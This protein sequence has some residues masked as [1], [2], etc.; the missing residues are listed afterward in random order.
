MKGH[1]IVVGATGGVGAG[2][3]DAALAAGYR[4]I[5]VGRDEE[6]LRT[7]VADRAADARLTALA[8]SLAD[9]A[10]AAALADE[11]RRLRVRLEGIVVSIAPPRASGRLVERTAPQLLACVEQDLIPHFLAARHLLPLLAQ[12]GRT[13]PYLVLGCAAADH[14]WAGYGHVSIG[15]A[16]RKMLVHVLREESKD[17]PVRVQLV[18][19]EGQVCTHRNARMACPAWS[20]AEAVGRRVV[21]LLGRSDDQSSVVRLRAAAAPS[22]LSGE[23]Q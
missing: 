4:V 12:R 23:G 17:L 20:T 16:A 6:R 2:V 3:V 10:R 8:G 7:L 5:A 13:T 1:L 9:E 19:I 14:A 11:V 22:I 15:S 21:E 18:Q